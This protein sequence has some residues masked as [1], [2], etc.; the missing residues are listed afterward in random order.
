MTKHPYFLLDFD[1]PIINHLKS[2]EINKS[3]SGIDLIDCIYVLNLEQRIEKWIRL[4]KLCKERNLNLNRFNAIDGRKL[5]RKIRDELAGPYPARLN[6]GQIGCLLSH[7]S[8]IKNAYDNNFN[9]IW[10]LEDDISF[11]GEVKNIPPLIKQLS[12]FDPDWDL[13]YTDAKCPIRI[14]RPS[15]FLDPRPSQILLPHKHYLEK[16][17]INS[18]ITKIHSRYG[19]YSV[20]I[21]RKGMKKILDYFLHVY[22]WSA[23]DIDI[24]Y[25]DN[26]HQYSSSKNIVTLWVDSP[27]SDTRVTS[28]LIGDRYLYLRD[29]FTFIRLYINLT[30]FNFKSLLKIK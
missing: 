23:L 26:L 4:E 16:K 5:S 29:Y 27:Y 15:F 21:S 13:F 6:G 7:L 10:I 18:N 11:E 14:L 30:F 3:P 24:H 9:N 12:E 1:A 2:F 8:I 22:I 17:I 20:I 19:F 28:S 25:I